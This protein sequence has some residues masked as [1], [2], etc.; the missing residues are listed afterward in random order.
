MWRDVTLNLFEGE[1][2]GAYVLPWCGGGPA[3]TVRAGAT[4][5][6]TGGANGGVAGVGGVRIPVLGTF[7]LGSAEHASG[8]A[9]CKGDPEFQGESFRFAGVSTGIEGTVGRFDFRFLFTPD[10]SGTRK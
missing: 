4:P 5:Q 2:G 3:V 8:G 9:E 10:I 7:Q 6:V 1:L